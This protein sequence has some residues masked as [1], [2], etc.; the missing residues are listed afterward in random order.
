MAE[1]THAEV[2]GWRAGFIT[3]IPRFCPNSTLRHRDRSLL[4]SKLSNR[5][6]SWL[7]RTLGHPDRSLLNRESG[8]REP[9]LLNRTVGQLDRF[10][11]KRGLCKHERHSPGEEITREARK[12]QQAQE[13]WTRRFCDRSCKACC[14][15]SLI[16]GPRT[17][18]RHG[19]QKAL[20]RG[21]GRREEVCDLWQST[22]PC[23]LPCEVRQGFVR[24]W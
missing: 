24:A 19:T 17:E 14:H 12:A 21:P 9:T 10:L 20:A 6:R 8:Q 2:A 16:S 22:E 7:I 18:F 11:P 13:E 5:D 15:Q 3:H 4:I 1:R 23:Q